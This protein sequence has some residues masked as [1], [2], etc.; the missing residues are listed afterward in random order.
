MKKLFSL[1][2][3][4]VLLATASQAQL[5]SDLARP[6]DFSGP[7]INDKAPTVQSR[8]NQF[9]NSVKM[10]H[11]YSM[12]F[13]SF[14]GGYQNVNAYTNTMQFDL[15]SRMSGRVDVSFLHSPFG[16]N[17]QF[18]NAGNFQNQVIIS[19]AELNYKISDKA[20]INVSFRQLPRGS[21]GYS[22]FGYYGYSPYNRYRDNWMW[23]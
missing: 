17:Q 14:G 4:V 3:F 9:F 16:G 6:N 2:L 21:Y 11:S 12:S 5:R 19:N 7:L 1:I 15:S 23:Y 8:L 10:S 18:M 13:S 22:P 20:F